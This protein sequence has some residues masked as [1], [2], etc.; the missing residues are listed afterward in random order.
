MNIFRASLYILSWIPVGIINLALLLIGIPIVGYFAR[1]PQERW[2]SWTWLWQND[3]DQ[4]DPNWYQL[5]FPELSP[6]MR[7][8]RYMAFRNPVNNH[9]FVFKEPRTFKTAGDPEAFNY[10][11]KSL[12]A[13]GIR[14]S[15]GWRYSGL[16]AGYKRTWLKGPGK[17]SEIYFGWKVGS[18][19][20]G[21]GF[22]VQLRFNR[23][24]IKVDYA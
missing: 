1:W 4:G 10:D 15:S 13:A 17:Y 7:R 19:V 5:R 21:L 6:Y 2:P 8:F 16:F 11:G 20:P 23:P 24:Y 22:T 12:L 9:R 14:S 18:P 3:E